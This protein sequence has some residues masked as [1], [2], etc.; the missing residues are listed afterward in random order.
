MVES[1]GMRIVRG[2]LKAGEPFPNEAE[3]GRAFNASRSVIREAVKS[4][5]ARGLLES[6]TRTGIRVLPPIHWNLLDI[7]VLGWRYEAMPRAQFFKE[8]F[9]IRR[10]IEPPASA[11]AAERATSAEIDSIAAAYATMEKADPSTETAIEADLRFHRGILIASHNDLLL[12]M[13]N[14]IGVGLLVSYR[15]S[16]EPYRVFLTK[17]GDVL[18]AI[19]AG[20]PAA[21]QK[22]M[23][24]LLSGTHDYLEAHLT[25]QRRKRRA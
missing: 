9:E 18:K 7:D 6:R 2:E 21:A 25:P 23:E 3:L 12:Q 20:K 22:A 14:L 11:L 16:T 4:L 17:H 8:L 24:A 5:A 10:M 13:G 15:I 1:L 19:V